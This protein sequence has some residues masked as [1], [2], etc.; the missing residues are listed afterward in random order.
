MYKFSHPSDSIRKNRCIYSL[1]TSTIAVVVILTKIRCYEFLSIIRS[2]SK[3]RN[4]FSNSPSDEILHFYKKKSIYCVFSFQKS[5]KLTDW[6]SCFR[7]KT[8]YKSQQTS[9]KCG[10]QTFWLCRSLFL[11]R[12]PHFFRVCLCACYGTKLLNSS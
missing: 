9:G 11:S 6:C 5:I 12:N 2:I 7:N 4:Q 1:I 8:W 3:H 10:F